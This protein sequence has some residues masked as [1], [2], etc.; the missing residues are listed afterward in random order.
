[1]VKDAVIQYWNK[2][3]KEEAKQM[4]TLKYLNIQKCSVEKPH[5]SYLATPTDPLKVCMTATKTKL[6]VQRYP[7]TALQASGKK[8]QDSC[9]ICKEDSETLP[10]FL[11]E[12]QP[13]GQNRMRYIGEIQDTL[14]ESNLKPLPLTEN[15][16]DWYVQL[17]LDST[18][19]VDEMRVQ[20][21]IEEIAR[22][23]IFNL[24]HKRT[25]ELGGSS[26]YSRGRY[27]GSI[28]K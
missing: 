12:C 6:L 25:I 27:V 9:P 15:T 8:K 13:I 3:L 2:Q 26:S 23:M 11:L 10:H 21:R 7:L 20:M 19:L 24:H 4:S 28:L 22:E 16:R 17:L 14:E 1:M 18:V 5:I